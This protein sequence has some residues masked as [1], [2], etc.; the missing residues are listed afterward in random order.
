VAERTSAPAGIQRLLG[1][2]G[3]AADDRAAHAD[4]TSPQIVKSWAGR[5]D[6]RSSPP[7]ATGAVGPSSYIQLINRGYAIYNR[8]G[9]LV[10]G[11]G[12]ASL[13]GAQNTQVGEPQ[14]HWDPYT[15]AFYYA[16]IDF[17]EGRERI[18]YGWS[19]S[20]KPLS[21]ADSQWCKYRYG[22][23]GQVRRVP[24]FPRLGDTTDF[25]AVGVN[26]INEHTGAYMRSDLVT[27]GKPAP[28]TTAS[29]PGTVDTT[30]FMNLSVEGAW[31][32]HSQGGGIPAYT[33]LPVAQTDPSDTGFVVA[34]D[35]N[36]VDGFGDGDGAGNALGIFRLTNDGGEPQLSGPVLVPVPAWDIPLPA[37]QRGTAVVLD[38]LDTRLTQ[39]MSGVD[40]AHGGVNAIWTQHTVLGGRGAAV[41]WYEIDPAGSIVQ[42][43]TVKDDDRFVYNA[44][45][46]SDRQVAGAGSSH[47]DAMVLTF[48]TSSPSEY[49]A[50]RMLSKVGVSSA[51]GW[52]TVRTSPGH[53][54]DFTCH[55]PLGP[56]CQWGDY[57]GASPD[58]VPSGT[59]RGY[60]WLV[61][62]WTLMSRDPSG[63]DWRTTVWQAAP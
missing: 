43:G 44:A 40:G 51:S 3:A 7:D 52:V 49:V 27:F 14:I 62:Q 21:G 20:P 55:Y 46:S 53:M 24:D 41:R 58:P 18:F 25:A 12:L 31:D 30:R 19:R 36:G 5:Y 4:G 57:P 63:V 10:Y 22:E 34:P 11:G 37:R 17:M 26:V 47:G 33:P 32:G 45:I 56:R 15:G 28:G 9:H 54:N 38:T 6:A 39:A 16:G 61:N 42:S 48:N 2:P 8:N 1:G 23:Y 35:L 60:V 29:C 59:A 50:I 13:F